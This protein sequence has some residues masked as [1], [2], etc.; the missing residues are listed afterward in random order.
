M[1]TGGIILSYQREFEKKIKVAVIG[2]GSHCYRNIL[3]SMTWLPVELVAL[4]DINETAVFNT[5]SQYNCHAYTDTRQMYEERKEIEAVF[6]S[7]SAGL[8]PYLVMEALELEKHVWVEKPI[9]VRASQVQ[10]ML[11]Y[12]GN[13]IVVAGLKKAFTPAAQKAREIVGSSEYGHLNSILAVYHMSMPAD[14]IRILEQEESP[15]WLR[16]GVHPLSF[17]INIGGRVLEVQTLVNDA[18]YGVVTL[19]F[20][21]GVFGTL[22]LASGP[23]PDV[24]QYSLYG[25]N[26]EMNISDARITLRRGIKDFNYKETTDYTSPGDQGGCVVWD[27]NSCV[28]TLENKAEFVQGIYS[29]MKYFCDC[30]LQNKK[31]EMGS[32][33]EALEVMQVYEAALLS[34]GK[35]VKIRRNY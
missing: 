3:P 1:N 12:A 20:E 33:M 22:H 7:V 6:I 24:E 17:M 28:A 29:E 30:I 15:N 25:D 16:N 19:R 21:N 32:L 2:I 31:P 26:W 11:D 5:A 18:G 27:I 4:C 34:S 10:E 9:A 13:Q 14:G 8:H 23:Q 35:P